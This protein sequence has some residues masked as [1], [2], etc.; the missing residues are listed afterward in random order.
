M[1]HPPVCP[2]CSHRDR[3]LASYARTNERRS[4]NGLPL[5][6]LDTIKTLKRDRADCA[7]RGHNYGGQPS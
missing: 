2:E 1:T 3:K 7:A 5:L 6:H 4:N